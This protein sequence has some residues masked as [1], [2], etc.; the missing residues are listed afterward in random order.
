MPGL[1]LCSAL[2]RAPSSPPRESIVPDV[3]TGLRW[4]CGDVALGLGPMA[5]A[6]S[7]GKMMS[8]PG[9]PAEALVGH[10]CGCTRD[11]TPPRH[12]PVTVTPDPSTSKLLT[13]NAPLIA[14]TNGCPEAETIGV[15]VPGPP[16][17]C[18]SSVAGLWAL[19]D[20]TPSTGVV[21]VGGGQGALSI[22]EGKMLG[23]TPEG[24]RCCEL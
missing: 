14:V 11:G 19:V 16:N 5:W 10:P 4:G 13:M 1:A 17:P 7:P 18:C 15:D 6:I 12:A 20:R 9:G 24:C 21:E 22:A 2:R 3:R 8:E 23:E